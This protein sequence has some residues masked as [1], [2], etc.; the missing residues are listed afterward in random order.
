MRVVYEFERFSIYFTFA[1]RR[2]ITSH[3]AILLG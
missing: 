2:A 1:N 3:R